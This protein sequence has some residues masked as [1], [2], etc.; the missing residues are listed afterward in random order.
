MLITISISGR[1]ES[2]KSTNVVRFTLPGRECIRKDMMN[3]IHRLGTS[4][5]HGYIL[6]KNAE[7]V[8]CC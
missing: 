8:L 1:D 3:K 6:Q 2:N 4:Y 5:I 7:D